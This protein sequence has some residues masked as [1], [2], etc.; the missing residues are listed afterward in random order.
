MTRTYRTRWEFIEPYVRGKVVLDIGPAELIG[1][2]NRDKEQESVLKRVTDS[3]QRVI[4]LEKSAEQVKAL[5]ER[6]YDIREG[7]AEDFCMGE[8]FDAIVAGELIEHLSNPGMFLECA[9]RHLKPDGVLLLTTP[10]RFGAGVFLSA[11]LHNRIPTYNKPIAKHVMYFDE[12]CL[13]DL[14]QRH[15]FTRFDLSNYEW[16]GRPAPNLT[17]SVLNALL[18]R[19]RPGFLSGL[20]IAARQ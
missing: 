3:A 7:D 2:I 17:T 19:I 6:G 10:N 11:L 14:L 8:M 15:G 4:G 13:R 16:V 20:M 5:R 12:N 9:K 1:T 18:R